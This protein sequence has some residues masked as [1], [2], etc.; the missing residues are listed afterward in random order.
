MPMGQGGRTYSAPAGRLPVNPAGEQAEDVN[1][2][3][4]ELQKHSQTLL[5]LRQDRDANEIANYAATLEQARDLVMATKKGRPGESVGTA[6]KNDGP[7]VTYHLQAR[8]SVPSRPDDQVVE[9]ARLEL[10]PDFYYKAV[11][12]LTPHVYR[13]AA[14]VNT[15]K[16]V[17]LPGEATMYH[18]SDFVGRM[19]LPL[20]AVGEELTVGFGAEPQLQVT[21]QMT[22]KQRAMQ[23]GNQVLKFDY[24][25]LVSSYKAEKV[26]VQVWDR[27]PHAES[28]A[29]VVDLLKSSP[30]VCKDPLYAREERANNLLRWDLLVEPGSRGEKAARVEY[31]F[32]LQLDKQATFGSFQTR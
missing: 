20:V 7:S 28:E 13:Q 2:A 14:L 1:K 26:K 12:V 19:A 31:E 27:L 4:K 32:K 16:H 9:I 30:E 8:L 3:I 11:P 21:R 15:S 23:G 18:G 17:L 24:R 25:I 6:R 29:M 5:N 10:E 22:D